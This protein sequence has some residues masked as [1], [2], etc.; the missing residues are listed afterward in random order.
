[1][2]M[3][4]QYDLEA[5]L[6]AILGALPSYAF[7]R[8]YLTSYQLAAKF[9]NDYPSETVAIGKPIGGLG[10]GQP[11][12]LAQYMGAELVLRIGD[13]R[14]RDIEAGYLSSQDLDSLTV[15]G[16]GSAVRASAPSSGFEIAIFRLKN[17]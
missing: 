7:G 17:G 13:G 15:G 2:S 3:W 12:S 11:N 8:P 14:I 1:M 9:A 5:K 4:Q 16:G 6:R 10:I